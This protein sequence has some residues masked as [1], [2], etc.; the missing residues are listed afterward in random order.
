[1]CDDNDFDAMDYAQRAALSRRQFNALTV[2]AGLV[3]MLPAVADAARQRRGRE[4]P[5]PRWHL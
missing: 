2:G 5:Y 1:M 4:H 3:S